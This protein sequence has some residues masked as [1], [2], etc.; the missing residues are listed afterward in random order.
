MGVPYFVMEFSARFPYSKM[1]FS[2]LFPRYFR[3]YRVISAVLKIGSPAFEMTLFH[4]NYPFKLKYKLKPGR[5]SLCILAGEDMMVI[6]LSPR[7]LKLVKA[8]HLISSAAFISA[9]VLSFA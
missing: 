6:F 1:E 8:F 9:A 5:I 7:R 3:D 4:L 2:V